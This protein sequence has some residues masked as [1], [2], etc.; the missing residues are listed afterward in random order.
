MNDKPATKSAETVKPS[1][2]Q[3]IVI[4]AFAVFIGNLLSFA[5]E[6]SVQHW[7]QGQLAEAEAAA[8]ENEQQ[9]QA[10][11]KQIEQRARQQLLDAVKK[12]Q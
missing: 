8:L 11:R 5:V 7:E 4:I 3:W 10:K 6:K 9:Q 12:I 2:T 1:T